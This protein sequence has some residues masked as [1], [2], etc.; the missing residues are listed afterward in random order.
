[1]PLRWRAIRVRRSS[2]LRRNRWAVGIYQR[3]A[4]PRPGLG[5]CRLASFR[6][7]GAGLIGARLTGA[8]QKLGKV[9][10]DVGGLFLWRFAGVWL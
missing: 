4:V 8:E 1:M 5:L 6:L 10:S 2:C 9:F 7:V 3:L